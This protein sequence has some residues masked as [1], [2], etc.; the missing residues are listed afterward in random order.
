MGKGIDCPKVLNL[1]ILVFNLDCKLTFYEQ[2]QSHRKERI[3]ETICKDVFIILQVVILKML[4]QERS[5]F[6][7]V[8]LHGNIS[9]PLLRVSD[10]QPRKYRILAHSSGRT[11]LHPPFS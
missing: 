11:D 10:Y 2:D 8:F 6:G 1:Q 9:L 4:C 5:D 3:D 7:F